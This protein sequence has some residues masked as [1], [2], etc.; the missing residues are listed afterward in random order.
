MKYIDYIQEKPFLGVGIAFIPTFIK[1]LNTQGRFD[2]RIFPENIDFY[3]LSSLGENELR[4]Q[5][6]LDWLP[7][8]NKKVTAHIFGFKVGSKQ[9]PDDNFISKVN[10]S[11][12]L[13]KPVFI[14]EDLS[15]FRISPTAIDTVPV[16]LT[17]ES[18]KYCVDALVKI[19]ESISVPFLLENPPILFT[20]GDIDFFQWL[21]DCLDEADSY[22]LFDLGH[23][24]SWEAVTGES[25]FERLSN[26]PLERV[27]EI[28]MAQGVVDHLS[29]YYAD[30][31]GE[32][33][34]EKLYELLDY[35][36][37]NCPN[38]KAVTLEYFNLFT[39]LSIGLNDLQK[40][41]EIVGRFISNKVSA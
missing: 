18:K 36:L 24:L 13:I 40:V 12:S 9:G 34:G 27:I 21:A 25:V 19:R 37:V 31:H 10:N 28:H 1:L 39:A 20:V 2:K 26:F 32:V 41:R 3:E 7:L 5:E 14:S 16:L 17:E 6:I 15:Q 29:K 4:E 22:C 38:L 23:L 11:I 8:L 33:Y 35:M 30:L